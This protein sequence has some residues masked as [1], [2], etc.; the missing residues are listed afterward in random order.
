MEWIQCEKKYVFSKLSKCIYF[1]YNNQIVII[2]KWKKFKY[3][4]LNIFKCLGVV[5]RKYLK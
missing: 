1:L 4:L 3:I 2:F 5:K